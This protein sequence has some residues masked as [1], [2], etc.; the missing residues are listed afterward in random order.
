[1]THVL[2]VGAGGA[3][4]SAAIE[5]AR[6]GAEVTLLE[7]SGA[8][9][10]ASGASGGELYLGGGT[11]LQQALGFDDTVSGMTAYLTAALGPHAD[12]ERIE[13]YAAGSVEHFDWLCGVGLDFEESFYDGLSWLP[14]A[15]HG[16]FWLGE[17]APPF[18]VVTP[19]VPRGHRP[20]GGH[21]AGK[22]VIEA[23]STTAE[24]LGVTTLL[25]TRL[26]ELLSDEGRVRGARVRGPEGE[27]EIRADAVVLTS[28]GFVDNTAMVQAHT[29]AL[30][31][32]G[33]ISN[34]TDDGSGI[35][36]AQAIGAATRHLDYCQAALTAVPSLA[37]GGMLVDSLGARFCA[38][39][40]YPGRFSQA[41]LE[42]PGPI[43]IITDETGLEAVP[44]DEL[45]G[46]RPS[47]G[48]ESLAELGAELGLPEGT[49]EATVAL[50]NLHA[51]HGEDPL[52]G[53]AARWLRPLE[54]PF[55]AVD[56]RQGFWGFGSP[57][58]LAGF[59]LGGLVTD[60]DGRVRHVSGEAI[61]GLFAAGR[62]TSSMHG[63]GYVSGTS[64]GDATY[65]GRRAGRAAAP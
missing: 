20:K 12:A 36:A 17:N 34:G 57:T 41:A 60:L 18:D 26:L 8:I 47:H 9:G 43:W 6:A 33:V 29:T 44:E 46:V 15:K 32:H 56:P 27:R 11:R 5:A 25:E 48:S 62:A 21:F 31:G 2:V 38:E 7:K 64:L 22:I 40:G 54:P 51:E 65:F 13:A 10:G 61:P 14:E 19:P 30:V 3:G 59:T 50:Y 35:V 52:W 63:E 45:W 23:L 28:G 24:S 4:L 42:R 58:G 1:M 49:L 16:L 39:D 37:A 53:K 55:A